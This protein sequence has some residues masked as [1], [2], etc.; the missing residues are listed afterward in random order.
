MGKLKDT[1]DRQLKTEFKNDAEKCIKIYKDLIKRTGS[2]WAS[3]W[4][5][6]VNTIFVGGGKRYELTKLGT[7]YLN[8][9]LLKNAKQ[10]GKIFEVSEFEVGDLI[11]H[12]HCF[13]HSMTVPFTATKSDVEEYSGKNG[14]YV[15]FVYDDKN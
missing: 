8:D 4:L 9:L 3:D 2:V 10:I 12:R 5:P 13:D 1:L 6:L 14:L 11:I 7:L 15:K